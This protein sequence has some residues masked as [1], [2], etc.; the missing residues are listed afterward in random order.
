MADSKVVEEF[1]DNSAPSGMDAAAAD[2]IAQIEA[3]FAAED[4]Q[5]LPDPAPEQA[6]TEDQTQEPAEVEAAGEGD[7]VAEVPAPEETD[8]G[9][10]RLV[11]REVEL[12]TKEKAFEER[13][14]RVKSVEA[15]NA[16]LREQLGKLPTDLIEDLRIRPL[17]AI[18][19]AGH[20]P[21]H[22]VRLILAAKMVREGRPVPPELKQALREAE[23]D[24][25]FKAQ[26]RELHEMKQQRAMMEFVSKV[27][28]EAQEYVS[29]MQ[30]ASGELK[31]ISKDAP[32]VAKVA[33]ANPQRVYSEI[34]DEISRDARARAQEPNAQ[35]ITYDEAARRVEKRWAEM[36]TLLGASPGSNASTTA[37]DTKSTSPANGASTKN[38][39]PATP[40]PL[41]QTKPKTQNELEEEAIQA[42]M[43]EFKRAEL[44]KRPRA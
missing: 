12:R 42:G 29:Q 24:Q 35:L 6:G 25:K 2:V 17:E 4:L 38:K 22:V 33:T 1:V 11:A 18:E 7:Q 8:R 14:A 3:E 32:T 28:R 9:L 15:E 44:A 36:A 13:E 23:Y 37:G 26:Q 31:G 20:D 41:T 30:K 16:Q 10:E 40:K 43:A 34:M 27:E 39:A 5:A 19:Q 21:D